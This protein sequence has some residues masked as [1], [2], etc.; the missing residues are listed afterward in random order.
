MSDNGL[1][2]EVTTMIVTDA[3]AVLILLTIL[4][5]IVVYLLHWL[6]R[7]S[8]KDQ[9][10]VRTGLG[11]ERVVMGGGALVIPIVHTT[12]AVN[13]NAI[14]VE[15]RRSGEQSLITAN[16]MRIDLVAE[17]FVRVIPTRDGVSMAARTLG[18][19]TRDP[20]ALKEIVQGRFVDAMSAVA[21][22]M[23]MEEIHQN[24]AKY[25]QAVADLAARTLGSNGLE[26]V[27]ASLTSLNQSDISIFNP[28]NAFDAEGLTQL[29]EHIEE[30]RKI[31]SR[32]ENESRIEIK[33]KDYVAEQRALEID[34]DLEYA[35][36]EQARCTRCAAP[37]SSRRS[38]RSARPRRSTSPTRRSGPSRRASASASPRTSSSRP[39]AST[40]RTRSRRWR[41]SVRRRPSSPRSAPARASRPSALQTPPEGRGGAH[42]DDRLVR[43]AEIRSRQEVAISETV[44][45]AEI[46]ETKL[47]RER[48]VAQSRIETT[49]A[50][51]ILSVEKAKEL[52]ISNELAAA[53]EEKA[54]IAK[55]FAIDTSASAAT[56]STR[57]ARS[58]RTQKIKLAETSA[59]RKIED[60]AIV[61]N[62]EVDELRI[63]A[64]KYVDRFEIEQELEVE[65]VDKERLI[66]VI[67]KS[68][69]EAYAKTKAA[70]AL[71]SLAA[72]EE[73]V[74]SARA[75]EAATRAKTVELI[76]ASAKAER[77]AVRL[78]TLAAAD[79]EAAEH[80]AAGE[81]ATAKRPGGALGQGG[82]GPAGAQRVENMRSEAS[83]KSAVYETLVKNLPSIIRE[84][85]RPMEKIE[86]IKIL[87][88]DGLPGL[89]S[90]SE[91]AGAGWRGWR[92]QHDRPRRQLGH[93]VPHPGR[94]R[95]RAD[96]G[97]GLP[98]ETLGSA[99]GMQ[100]RNFSGK[101][102][103]DN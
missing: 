2:Q 14:P 11:G 102:E 20:M 63:A 76:D 4:V 82:G 74:V 80:R 72:M 91:T 32:I 6:Y 31:R 85:V 96:E 77:E 42:R 61:A 101:E 66:A 47:E 40:P 95:G 8:S 37:R 25:M 92:R 83:R 103:G 53:E 5:A 28:S 50:I 67:N 34:R 33:L 46:E 29:T 87:Q 98:I 54:T 21:A 23:T 55:R 7:H 30:R 15:I 81:I 3:I 1:K 17:F 13:M 10:F 52:R 51:E 49:N 97:L 56:R 45:N 36:I 88:V 78:V 62:R 60:A 27:N 12:T 24:R 59:F 48:A 38:R 89:N 18:D 69:E 58:P 22:T 75:E 16:K 79:K 94:L 26:L 57:R 86:S 93:E 35:R 19:R 9:S 68:I 43:E 71:K 64:R 99:G 100:F 70:E 84:T 65:I 73:Q 41:S 44:A 90:P 39:S